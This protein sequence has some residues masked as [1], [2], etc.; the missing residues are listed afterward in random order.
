MNNNTELKQRNFN[1]VTP[2]KEISQGI[3][4][5]KRKK[6]LVK[7]PKNN[8]N[9]LKFLRKFIILVVAILVL[10]LCVFFVNKH[11][12]NKQKNDYINDMVMQAELRLNEND[13]EGAISIYEDILKKYKSSEIE[14]KLEQLK[15]KYKEKLEIEAEESIK[16]NEYGEAIEKYRTLATFFNESL[17]NEKINSL[18][19][20]YLNPIIDDVEQLL[21]VGNTPDARE[22]LNA[23]TDEIGYCSVI[24][25][26]ENIIDSIEINML[27]SYAMD[28]VDSDGSVFEEYDRYMIFTFY[29]T[30]IN[31]YVEATYYL[32]G[33]YEAFNA[34]I[35]IDGMSDKVNNDEDGIVLYIYGDEDLLYTSDML[36][37][38]NDTVDAVYI[39]ISGLS[40][41][42]EIRFVARGYN[43]DENS[44]YYNDRGIMFVIWK[45]TLV[46]KYNGVIDE[47]NLN[48]FQPSS[49]CYLYDFFVNYDVDDYETNLSTLNTFNTRY[50]H[51][52]LH[53][54]DEEKIQLGFVVEQTGYDDSL[55]LFDGLM[56]DGDSACISI[57]WVCPEEYMAY[58]NAYPERI[59]FYRMDTGEQIGYIETTLQR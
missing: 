37:Y 20:E 1:S 46:L 22:L 50:Y 57:D 53:L 17:Y 59:K 47:I 11:I 26:E 52:T 18:T 28:Y 16:K 23:A 49:N 25:D 9:F 39:N 4:K 29:R 3:K 42:Q 31:N 7:V 40:G 2:A 56:G 35:N 10:F 12:S 27:N 6:V 48:S 54:D 45:P 36:N 19:N 8:S 43:P 38:T 15:E 21:Y 44:E 34:R 5:E 32:G 30:N 14:N 55:E 51:F 13:Y 41:Y 24:E 58:G 33:K